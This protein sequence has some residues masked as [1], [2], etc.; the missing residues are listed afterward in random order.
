[1]GYSLCTH[2]TDRCVGQAGTGCSTSATQWLVIH[3]AHTAPTGVWDRLGQGAL[4]ALH[5]DMLFTVHTLHRQVCGTGWDRVLYQCCTMTCYS[6]CTHCTDRC[7]GQGALPVLHDI[8]LYPKMCKNRRHFDH[9]PLVCFRS[10][11]IKHTYSL[12]VHNK[13]LQCI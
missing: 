1:M 9:I 3:C 8:V 11:M 2:Y 10:K 7:V 13:S 12:I 6:L 5:N 4:P